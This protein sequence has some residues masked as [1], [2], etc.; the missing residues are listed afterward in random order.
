MDSFSM[1]HQV[2]CLHKQNQMSKKELVKKKRKKEETHK[3]GKYF[4]DCRI[5]NIRK[6]LAFKRG[7]S[8]LE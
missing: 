8:Y 3:E 1:Y 7:G 4:C 2:K 5:R 6:W